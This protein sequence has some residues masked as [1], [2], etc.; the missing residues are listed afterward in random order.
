MLLY[1]NPKYFKYKINKVLPKSKK[2]LVTNSSVTPLLLVVSVDLNR[3]YV[4][5]DGEGCLL[6]VN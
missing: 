2:C 3:Y 4:Q 1:S 6:Y 5:I